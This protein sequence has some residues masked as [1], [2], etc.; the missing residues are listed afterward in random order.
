MSEI[1]DKFFNLFGVPEEAQRAAVSEFVKHHRITPVMFQ[2]LLASR[3]LMEEPKYFDG[4]V[5]VAMNDVLTHQS[6]VYE[7]YIA[8]IV[9]HTVWEALNVLLE[10]AAKDRWAVLG[11][12]VQPLW[13]TSGEKFYEVFQGLSAQQR[14][15]NSAHVLA[16][17]TLLQSPTLMAQLRH[18]PSAAYELLHHGVGTEQSKQAAKMLVEGGVLRPQDV[19]G[20]VSWA[21]T[22]GKDGQLEAFLDI[23]P[24]GNWEAVAS[25]CGSHIPACQ[26][27]WHRQNTPQV[28]WAMAIEWATALPPLSDHAFAAQVLDKVQWDEDKT[29]RLFDVL[30]EGGLKNMAAR[31]M[32]LHALLPETGKALMNNIVVNAAFPL[33]DTFAA[34]R[35]K[36][37]LTKNLPQHPILSSRKHKL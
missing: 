16:H 25:A 31:L 15:R 33:D 11:D 5:D 36:I 13:E 20:F 32:V 1:D 6:A 35:E 3:T 10:W 2:E 37:V 28:A 27:V 34:F 30:A 18:T 12:I 19:L 9:A 29:E 14:Q 8:P 4:I 7:N 26:A 24:I 21:L 23:L 17:H 22:S